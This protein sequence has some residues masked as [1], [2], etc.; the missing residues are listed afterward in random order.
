MNPSLF[1]KERNVS[2]GNIVSR[3]NIKSGNLRMEIVYVIARLFR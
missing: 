3:N 1:H 2:V